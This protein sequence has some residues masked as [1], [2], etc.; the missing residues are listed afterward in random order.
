MT[1]TLQSPTD[2]AALRDAANQHLFVGMNNAAQLTEEG[3]P[4]VMESAEGIYVTA[5]DG[6][7]YIDGISGMYFRNV[8]HGREEIAR[9]VYEQ[10][11]TISMNVYAGATPATIE[12][13]VKLAEITPGDLTRTFFCQ[14]GSEANESSLK[15]AQA[16]HVRRR[17][18]RAQ[19]S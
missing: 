18:E 14:G 16:Y 8:G 10:L 2:H 1:T 6:K 7:K 9:A 3:G 15:L 5:M 13:A 19:G 12:L 4:L 17:S 11:A